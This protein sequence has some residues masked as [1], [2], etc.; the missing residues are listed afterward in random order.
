[1]LLGEFECP[2]MLS[3]PIWHAFSFRA[4]PSNSRL[5]Q[6]TGRK[7]RDATAQAPR[8][9]T[10]T[11]A[12]DARNASPTA[13]LTWRPV[14]TPCAPR[15]LRYSAVPVWY[16]PTLAAMPPPKPNRLSHDSRQRAVASR[17]R[18]GPCGIPTSQP[19]T[20]PLAAV[21][22]PVRR[23]GPAPKDYNLWTHAFPELT[24]ASRRRK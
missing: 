11:P 15:S 10:P 17:T 7:Q 19:V 8:K 20:V 13:C 18:S 6:L 14:A 5:L 3:N 16:S 9:T 4:I 2:P 23:P 22:S 12:S 1:M 24:P 21:A